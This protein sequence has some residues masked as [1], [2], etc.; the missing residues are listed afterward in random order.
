[1]IK[2]LKNITNQSYLSLLLPISL[3]LITQEKAESFAESFIIYAIVLIG[4]LIIYRIITN[5]LIIE[6]NY[7]A[8]TSGFFCAFLLP[9]TS[10]HPLLFALIIGVFIGILQVLLINKK[11]YKSLK[12]LL[13]R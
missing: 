10:I 9:Y 1:M 3:L 4:T 12:L 7:T 13:F 2:Q 6:T 5:Y 8:V 11:V